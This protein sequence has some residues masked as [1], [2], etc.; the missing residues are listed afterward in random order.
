MRRLSKKSPVSACGGCN[1]VFYCGTAHQSHDRKE[2]RAT[3]TKIKATREKLGYEEATLWARPGDF[4][5]PAGA[6]TNG[7]GNFWGILD[8]RDNMRT[9]FA[10]ADA[11]LKVDNDIVVVKDSLD[12]FMDILRLCRS[13]NL[14]LREIVPGLLLRLDREQEFYDFI[15]LWTTTD[16]EVTIMDYTARAIQHCLISTPAVPMPLSPSKI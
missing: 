11:L 2:H 6:F 8:T 4:M 5:L 14:S 1:V 9:R 12:H 7:V 3:C 16:D 15:K 13:D 10:A